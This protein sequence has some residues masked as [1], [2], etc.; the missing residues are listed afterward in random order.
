MK[1]LFILLIC[2]TIFSKLFSQVTNNNK[3]NFSNT[4]WVLKIENC[5][6]NYYDFKEHGSY[7]YYSGERN[8]YYPGVYSLKRILYF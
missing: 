2:V 1:R 4:H 3:Y 6:V 8:E 7:I 5:C